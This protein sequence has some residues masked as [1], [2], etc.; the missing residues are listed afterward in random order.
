M[1]TVKKFWFIPFS[2]ILVAIFFYKTILHGYLPFP[3]DLLVAEYKPWS[4]YSY[5]GYNPGSYPNKAQYFDTLRQLYPWKTFVIDEF[6]KG[7]VPLWNPH[8]FSGSALDKKGRDI[9]D[10]APED[11]KKKVESLD[12]LGQNRL[13]GKE[14]FAYVRRH[15]T[16]F[17]AR[18]LKK[19][20]YFW[21][22]SPQAGIL[23]PK[24]WLGIYKIFYVL[25]LICGI[26]GII[27]AFKQ[28][29]RRRAQGSAA[30]A[31]LLVISVSLFQS[32]FYVEVRHRWAIEPVFLIFAAGG[33][34][35]CFKRVFWR[36]RNENH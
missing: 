16:G 20:Y 28:D 25:A 14:A 4:S 32:L 2:R 18:T 8:N 29:N 1:T 30:L 11:F 6:K 12:E 36:T 22:F 13:F 7:Q 3:G 33:L 34:V 21:W 5:L 9:Y 15:P 24:L 17:L 26:L 27:R 19:F 31:A 10:L 23:Y 35:Y